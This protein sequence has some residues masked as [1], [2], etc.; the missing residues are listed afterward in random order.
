M[1]VLSV[2]DEAV[3]GLKREPDAARVKKLMVYACTSRWESDTRRLEQVAFRQLVE[4]LWLLAPTLE[5]LRSHLY[6]VVQT[7]N[8]QAEYTLVANTIL[9]HLNELYLMAQPAL[10]QTSHGQYGEVV[11][12]IE[13][14]EDVLRAKK[15]LFCACKNSWQNDLSVLNEFSLESLVE[16]L[17]SLAPTQDSLQKLLDSI[18][19]TLNRPALYQRIARAILD[20]FSPLYATEEHTCIVAP[21]ATQILVAP[22]APA[23]TQIVLPEAEAIAP[24]AVA[25]LPA[26][27]SVS[28]APD[29]AT[30]LSTLFDLRLEVMKYT[31][32]LRAKLLLFS[33]I[34]EPIATVDHGIAM[35]RSHD[36]SD[37]LKELL[38]SYPSYDRAEQRLRA[39]APQLPNPQPYQQAIGAILRAVQPIYSQFTNLSPFNQ[40]PHSDGDIT[41][42]NASAEA[43]GLLDSALSATPDAPP[44]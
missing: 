8:K 39:I 3:Q 22:P 18:V 9:H 15:L 21:P 36:L 33:C 31:N 34:R 16:E 43:T 27:P 4:Q 42:I 13:H 7:L 29:E 6:Q 24:E 40:T 41:K 44:S 28:P 37:L 25:P 30:I 38:V 14:S 20:A 35:V 10:P 12:A 2:L 26:H 1:I 5:Q 17:H 23:T 19:R 11:R 32:P